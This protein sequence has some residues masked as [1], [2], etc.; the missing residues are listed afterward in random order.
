MPREKG[1][2]VVARNRKAFHDYTIGETWEAGMVLQGTEVKSLRAGKASLGDAFA[3]VDDRGEVW[4]YNLHIPEYAFGTWRNHDVMRKRKLLLSKREIAKLARESTDSGKTIVPLQ[5]YFKD[6][7][8][9]VEIA[10]GTGKRDWDKR[11]S[12]KERDAKREAQRA[13]GTRLKRGRR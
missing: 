13:I 7:Y 1:Q 2:K 5:L 11:Q 3:Q 10:V 8:A 9:K 6:G 12:I 4:L